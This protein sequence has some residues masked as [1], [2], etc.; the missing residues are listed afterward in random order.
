[1]LIF[2]DWGS[3]D[4]DIRYLALDD[5]ASVG[6][7]PGLEGITSTQTGSSPDAPAAIGETIV[8]EGWQ[9]TVLETATRRA[10]LAGGRGSE[11]VQ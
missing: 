5:G 6:V 9:V 4:D 8:A 10:G 3:F 11:R 7:D 2:E 1:M